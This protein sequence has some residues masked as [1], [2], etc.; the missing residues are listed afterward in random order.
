VPDYFSFPREEEKISKFWEDI[1][2]FRTSL[3]LSEGRPRYSFYDGPPFATGMPHYGHILAGTI[4]DIVTRFA[5]MTGHYV[6]RR[7][8]WDCHG[9]PVEYEIDK[10][11]GISGPEDVL[12]MGIANYNAQCR[13]IVMRYAHEWESVVKRV[14]RWIDFENDYKTLDTTFMESVWWVFQQLFEKGLVYRGFKVSI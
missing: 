13:K 12:K 11:L 2:A 7:F 14:G 4:K 1:D 6:E 9:L 10:M 3:K 8:G 5:H